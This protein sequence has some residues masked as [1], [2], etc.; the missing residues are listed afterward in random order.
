MLVQKGMTY[1]FFIKY[2]H[3]LFGKSRRKKKVEMKSVWNNWVRAN[4]FQALQNAV[5]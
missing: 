3:L 2:S 4:A 1:L 5:F